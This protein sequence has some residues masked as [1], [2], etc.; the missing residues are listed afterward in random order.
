MF[1]NGSVSNFQLGYFLFRMTLGVNFFFHGFI[2]IITGLS[3]WEMGQAAAFVDNPILSMWAV[4]AFLYAL[5][6]VEMVLGA[7]VALGLFTRWAL[8]GGVLLMLV[9][10]FGNAT[11]QA[12][13]TVGNNMH[14]VL[15][16]CLLIYRLSDNWLALDNR[17][18]AKINHDI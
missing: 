10:I 16:H 8:V 6:F 12:W 11:R 18:A 15:Y 5:P 9:L 1:A 17:C 4:H 13:S 3:A 2:R 14:Y 7:L